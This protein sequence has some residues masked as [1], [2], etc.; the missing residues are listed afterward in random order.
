MKNKLYAFSFFCLLANINLQAQRHD[1]IVKFGL[2]EPF[3]SSMGLAYERF[4][5]GTTFSI[6][7]YGSLT[8][9]NV[10]IWESLRPTMKGYSAE[11]QGRYYY[12]QKNRNT[13][14]GIY[15]GV[16][17]K[18]GETQITMKVPDGVVNFLDG[19]SKIFGLFIGYQKAFHNRFFIDG[20]LGSGFHKAD[21]SGRFSDKGRVIPSVI[22]SGFIP[23]VDLRAGIA[24]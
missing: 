10:K 3:Y 18:Y 16:F 24:F 15:N 20:T 23:K 11:V 13:V 19:N 5:P 21:Y 12:D 22:A 9:R 7:A 6:Q 8:L 14:S 1:N 4:I 2:I 17:A